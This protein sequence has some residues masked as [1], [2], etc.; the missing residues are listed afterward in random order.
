MEKLSV[1]KSL[2]YKFSERF[3]VKGLGL[4]ISIVL[5]RLMAPEAFGQIAIMTVVINISLIIAEGGLGAAIVQ[6]S[7]VDDRDYSTVFYISI[8]FSAFIL[9][10]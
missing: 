2:I 10:P 5:A 6:S 4:V 3:A 7:S 1:I 9:K 8:L